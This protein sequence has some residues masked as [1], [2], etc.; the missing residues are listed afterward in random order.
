MS[1]PEAPSSHNAAPSSVEV[2]R[3][4]EDRRA[5]L[6]PYI[7]QLEQPGFKQSAEARIHQRDAEAFAKEWK[8]YG[9]DAIDAA[10]AAVDA[11][12]FKS[13]PE[14]RIEATSALTAAKDAF[15]ENYLIHTADGSGN[16]ETPIDNFETDE[17]PFQPGDAVVAYRY[18]HKKNEDG[19]FLYDD[20]GELIVDKTQ[21]G[22][23][24]T[25]W[26]VGERLED[27]RLRIYKDDGQL[28]DGTRTRIKKTI[29]P[30]E[31]MEWQALAQEEAEKQR[32][33]AEFSDD[34]YR[35]F[36]QSD[37]LPSIQ[38]LNGNIPVESVESSTE[39]PVKTLFQQVAEEDDRNHAEKQ[40]REEEKKFRISKAIKKAVGRRAVR[41]LAERAPKNETELDDSDYEEDSDTGEKK[42]LLERL[43]AMRERRITKK[44]AALEKKLARIDAK[45]ELREKQREFN[46]AWDEA[47][48]ENEF[49]DDW[50]EA[51][52]FNEI[53]DDVVEAHKIND[54][55]DQAAYE[56]KL[57]EKRNAIYDAANLKSNKKLERVL[58]KTEKI[59]DKAKR[60]A[61]AVGEMSRFDKIRARAA[62]SI[63]TITRQ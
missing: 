49:R 30:S 16:S 46:T 11:L 54:A 40:T 59:Q 7:E 26:T 53:H 41:S 52:R 20:K 33:N 2:L 38:R 4:F 29:S 19:S 13:T 39:I 56:A 17:N 1:S 58:K 43:K 32:A 35:N 51:H 8:N 12:D 42:S 15:Y 6:A 57:Q 22:H 60:E 5:K 61:E 34:D 10:Q 63:R 24:E 47:H 55:I 9:G 45:R 25:G 27:G 62:Q 18:K 31:L 44:M 50:D 28:E 3:D 37:L 14:Q 21:R 36:I 48:A 23:F